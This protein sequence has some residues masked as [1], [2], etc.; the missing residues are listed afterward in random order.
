MISTALALAMSLPLSLQGATETAIA[1]KNDDP[2]TWTVE[3]PRVIQPQVIA[4][5]NCLGSS[6]RMVRGKA[7]FEMQHRADLPRCSEVA[8]E[9]KAEAIEAMA[10]TKTTISEQDLDQ[11]FTNIGRIHVARGR[12]L[13]DQFTQRLQRAEARQ[14]NYSENR[15]EGRILDRSIDEAKAETV[16]EATSAQD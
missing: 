7:D 12:D 3:Y 9:S 8:E 1:I 13:D 11:L 14:Q 2:E 16:T 5:R 4:Y 6:N 15:P 10:N